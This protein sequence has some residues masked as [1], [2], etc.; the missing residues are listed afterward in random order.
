MFC[1]I[2]T[3]DIATGQRQQNTSLLGGYSAQGGYPGYA[4]MAAK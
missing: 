4:I 1:Q 3:T 2:M